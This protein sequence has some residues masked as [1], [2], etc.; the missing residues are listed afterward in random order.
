MV[1]RVRKVY[2]QDG[3]EP[4]V[5]GLGLPPLALVVL[6]SMPMPF[7]KRGQCFGLQQDRGET[8]HWA[9]KQGE[10]EDRSS[11]IGNVHTSR[12]KGGMKSKSRSPE[13]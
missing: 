13:R 4:I 1:S 6:G 3:Q 2:C 9:R 5:V 8:G 7:I 10:K 11:M 12:H